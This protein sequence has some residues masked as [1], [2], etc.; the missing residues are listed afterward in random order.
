MEREIM[1]HQDDSLALL[2]RIPPRSTRRIPRRADADAGVNTD[3]SSSEETH[4]EYTRRR[5]GRRND[6]SIRVDDVAQSCD[7]REPAAAHAG[8]AGD[9]GDRGAGIRD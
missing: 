3:P 5:P 1:G 2:L 8:H 9:G 7:Q 4:R 6:A